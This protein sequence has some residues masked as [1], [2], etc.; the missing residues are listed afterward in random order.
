MSTI[1]I[2]DDHSVIRVAVRCML[3]EEG[4]S[5]VADVDN[6]AD[7]IRL[8]RTL[9][10]E[11]II[12]D[13]CLPNMDGVELLKRL[14]LACPEIKSIVFSAIQ[15]EHHITYCMRAGAL[16]FVS[17]S[18]DFIELKSAVKAVLAGYSF[19]PFGYNNE[20]PS[21]LEG[22]GVTSIGSL[23]AKELVVFNLLVQGYRNKDIAE[24]LFLSEKTIGTYKSRIFKKMNIKSIVELLDIAKQIDVNT[25]IFK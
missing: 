11:L 17:K 4:Y 5:V 20:T 14:H 18:A 8:A 22:G 10:P 3:E 7:A 12:V 9:L 6:G 19:I 2:V 24:R 1:M 25:S 15:A 16:A 23:S 13:I 21:L